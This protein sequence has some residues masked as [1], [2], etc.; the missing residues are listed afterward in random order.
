MIDLNLYRKSLISLIAERIG[1]S[2]SQSNG[3]PSIIQVTNTGTKPQYPYA[4]LDFL[5]SR[6]VAGYTTNRYIN[7]DGKMV[8]ETHKDLVFTIGVRAGLADSFSLLTHVHK[9]FTFE[10]RLD[11]IHTECQATITRTTNPRTF[12]EVLADRVQKYSE[13]E[14]TLRIVDTEID[15]NSDYIESIE[16]SGE[17]GIDID[18]AGIFTNDVWD[19]SGVFYDNETWGDDYSVPPLNVEIVIGN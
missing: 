16:V 4:T 15:T 1:D 2:L 18:N 11:Q 13:F 17:V 6:D 9:A 10:T 12:N 3:R 7:D 19:N 8:Y 5:N 14:V